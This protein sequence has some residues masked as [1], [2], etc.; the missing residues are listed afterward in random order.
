MGD[1]IIKIAANTET[2]LA[3]SPFLPQNPTNYQAAAAAEVYG[4]YLA[5]RDARDGDYQRWTGDGTKVA[6]TSTEIVNLANAHVDA[7]TLADEDVLRVAVKVNGEVLHRVAASA[8]PGAGEFKTSGTT[9]I[10]F[11]EAPAAGAK[12]EMFLA[13]T[14]PSGSAEDAGIINFTVP[15]DALP[16][17]EQAP[18]VVYADAGVTATRLTR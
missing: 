17:Q 7:G 9:T 15:G 3:V 18:E 11:G 12:V 1:Q 2:V 13:G 8:T 6:W 10:T 16:F 4:V 5:G 14:D